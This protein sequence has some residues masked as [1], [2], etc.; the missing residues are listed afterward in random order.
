MLYKTPYDLQFERNKELLTMVDNTRKSRRFAKRS[1]LEF[2]KISSY[3]ADRY[4]A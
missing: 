2:L 4:S 3:F 1:Q